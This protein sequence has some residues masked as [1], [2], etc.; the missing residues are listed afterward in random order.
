M[1]QTQRSSRVSMVGLIA[2][3]FGV[4]AGKVLGIALFISSPLGLFSQFLRKKIN[5]PSFSD[6]RASLR[7]RSSL[8]RHFM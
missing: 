7:F 3:L 8:V 6:L 1:N 4:S 5:T 2:V